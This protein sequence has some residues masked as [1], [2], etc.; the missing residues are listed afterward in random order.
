MRCREPSTALNSPMDVRK[1]KVVCW[2]LY[3]GRWLARRF[4]SPILASII[5]TLATPLFAVE[6][7][8]L[9]AA[10]ETAAWRLLFDGR[11]TNGWRNFKHDVIDSGWKVE[12][13]TLRRVD[14]GAGDYKKSDLLVG[15]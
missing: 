4:P 13:G 1:N 9:T 3:R 10:E 15:F 6:P 14:Y 5:A 8:T 2:A 7:N 11:S 12:N